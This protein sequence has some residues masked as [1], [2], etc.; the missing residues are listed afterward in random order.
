MARSDWF[1][2]ALSV[3]IIVASVVAYALRVGDKGVVMMPDSAQYLEAALSLHEAGTLSHTVYTPEAGFV[4][5]PMTHYPPLTS[6]FYALLLALG[7]ALPDVHYMT[8]LIMLSLLLMGMGLLAYRFSGSTSIAAYTVALASISFTYLLFFQIVLSEVIFLPLLVFLMVLLVDLPARTS[9][10]MPRLAGATVL[11]ALLMLTRYSGVFVYGAVGLW[12][13]GH[14]IRQ[15]APGLLLKELPV[16]ALAGL[17]LLFWFIR[18]ARLAG[19]V[20]GHHFEPSVYSF[21]D[22]VEKLIQHGAAT[23]WPAFSPQFV[24]GGESLRGSGLLRLVAGAG[25]YL[26]PLL[27]VGYA[28]WRYRSALKE[29]L[30]MR[31]PIEVT[32]FIYLILVYVVA[33]PFLS[34]YPID[35]R[36]MA[37]ALCLMQPWLLSGFVV[38]PRRT[39]IIALGTY[40]AVNVA[41]LLLSVF[42]RGTPDVLQPRLLRVE[43][44]AGQPEEREHYEQRHLPDWLIFSAPKTNDL[45]RYH[46]RLLA[47]INRENH[48]LTND[49]WADL[50]FRA[51]GIPAADELEGWLAR[52]SCALGVE[53][54]VVVFDWDRW[55]V[56]AD[57]LRK[58]VEQKCPKLVKATF[59]HSTVYHVPGGL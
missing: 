55:H 21:V 3:V 16:L 8:A 25:L 51:R 38:L 24:F 59:E 40:M 4:E 27:F 36:D 12:W 29:R 14:R 48:V 2:L 47:S 10:V 31:S 32:L 44:L 39:R 17:P 37:T 11:L 26:L 35:R 45:E 7:V 57:D 30:W 6:S 50:L 56:G 13:I 1:Y 19:E 22:G 43:D 15:R 34:F 28:L 5:A 23:F 41:L 33:Q 49:D 20:A 46:P 18:N 54:R 9:G 42:W 52:G 53:T 58:D